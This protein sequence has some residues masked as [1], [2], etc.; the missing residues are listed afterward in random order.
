MSRPDGCAVPHAAAAVPP[1]PADVAAAAARLAPWV[2]E[3]PLVPAAGSGVW[4]KAEN[5]HPTGSFKLRGAFNAMLTLAPEAARAGVVAHSSGNHAMAVAY[6]AA[7][8]GVSATVV[9][10][11][12]APAAKVDGVRRWGAEIVQVG[13]ASAERAATAQAI[14]SREGRAL[15]EPYDAAAIIAATGVIAH[16]IVAALPDVAEVHVPVSGGGLLAGVALAMA[17]LRPEA[18]VVGV[19]PEVAAD[20]AL[21]FRTGRLVELPAEQMALTCA[22]GLRVQRLGDLNWRVLQGLVDTVTTVS[23]AEIRHAMRRLARETRLV[24]EPSGAV[25][26]AAAFRAA[27]A[28]RPRVAILS[29]GNLDMAE[30]A[31]VLAEGQDD[32]A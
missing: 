27:P 32:I 3:T 14:A 9:M 18:R 31:R 2:R 29:G 15:I 1:T 20:A 12:D 6:A 17:A 11:S 16:E 5:L 23:E 26:P 30:Y 10:P 8:L 13:P 25:A 21:S 4:L 19:E 24:A 22:D 7:R 28:G